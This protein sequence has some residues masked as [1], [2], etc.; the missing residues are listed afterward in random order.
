VTSLKWKVAKVCKEVEDIMDK[1]G[2]ENYC[3]YED[4]EEI[5]EKLQKM[6]D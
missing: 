1:L 2:D 3:P 5:H 4:L 6:T